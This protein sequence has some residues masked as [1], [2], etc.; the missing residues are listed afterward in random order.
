MAGCPGGKPYDSGWDPTVGEPGSGAD[1]RISTPSTAATP[2]GDRQSAGLRFCVD[3]RLVMNR[4]R[5]SFA[6]LQHADGGV[7]CTGHLA[8]HLDQPFQHALQ[9][10][11]RNQAAPG[12]E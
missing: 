9:V 12:V 2:G 1:P 10:E 6:G 4:S 3:A 7:A 5:C 8:R 11:L